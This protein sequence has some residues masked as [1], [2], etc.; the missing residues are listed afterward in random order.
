[1]IIGFG[2]KEEAFERAEEAA[3]RQYV[4]D[5]FPYDDADY[6]TEEFGDEVR[7]WIRKRAD[8]YQGKAAAYK[9]SATFPERYSAYWA[10]L[11]HDGSYM[12]AVVSFMH[13]NRRHAL[14]P[15]GWAVM[16]TEKCFHVKSWDF[17]KRKTA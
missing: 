1:M 7:A 6:F 14:S 15:D 11:V 16:Q 12:V 17:R 3:F 2:S 5:N 10:H 4:E 8:D 9:D 13:Y